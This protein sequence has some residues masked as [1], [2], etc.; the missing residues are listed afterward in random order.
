[1]NM[2][3]SWKHEHLPLQ[4]HSITSQK[5]GVFNCTFMGQEI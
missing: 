1:M 2:L 3:R 4:Q 5:T